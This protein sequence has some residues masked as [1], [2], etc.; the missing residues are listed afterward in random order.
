MP[1]EEPKKGKKKPKLGSGSM[2]GGSL[3][4]DMEELQK[5]GGLDTLIPQRHKGPVVKQPTLELTADMEKDDAEESLQSRFRKKIDASTAPADVEQAFWDL[6]HDDVKSELHDVFDHH[7]LE[8]TEIVAELQ[9]LGT[10]DKD[11]MLEALKKWK[12]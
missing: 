2:I 12:K 3:A 4:N 9:A 7:E 1:K 10:T 8:H 6:L 11:K 5:K